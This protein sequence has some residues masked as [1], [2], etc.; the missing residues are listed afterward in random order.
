MTKLNDLLAKREKLEEQ[1]DKLN[2]EI[3]TCLSK[4]LFKCSHCRLAYEASEL[5]VY[6][7]E[8]YNT[9]DEKHY[10]YDHHWYCDNRHQNKFDIEEY[11]DIIKFI[12][13]ELT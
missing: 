7:R 10:R 4:T 8:K 6:Y 11:K 9:Y 2:D 12:D 5:V 1:L 3:D 13:L